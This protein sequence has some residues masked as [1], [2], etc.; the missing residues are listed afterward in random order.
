MKKS[1]PTHVISYFNSFP[2]LT[3]ALLLILWFSSSMLLITAQSVVEQNGRLTVTG[4]KVTNQSGSPISLAGNSIFWSNYSEGAQFYTAQ[5]VSKIAGPEWNSSII[6]AA[7]GVEDYNGYISNP[8]QEKAKV[9]AIVDAAIAEGIYVI[10]DWHSHNAEDYQN[11]AVQFFTE[12]SQLYGSYPNVIYE[13]YNEPIGQPWSEIKAYA[14]AVTQAIRSNDPDNLIVVGTSFY[15]QKVTQASLNPLNDQNTAYT[16]HFYAGT[17]GESLR[18]DARTAM[19]NGIA[20]FVTEWGAVNANGDGGAAIEET[21][22]WMEFL[23]ENHISHAN[24]SISD[25][26]E[27]ASV[28]ASGTGINGLIANNLTTIGFFVQ[29]IIKNWTTSITP[30][31]T[32][33]T[34]YAIHNI[35]GTIEAED[36]DN[37]GN[38]VAYFDSTSGNYGNSLRSDD[39]DKE[40]TTDTGGGHNVG[41]TTDG[42]WLEYT[43]S[44][45]TAGTYDI[46]FRV[47]STRSSNKSISLSLE[48]TSLGTIAV[49]NTSGWQQWETVTLRDIFIAGGKDQVMRF[50]FNDGA[51]NLN[52]TTFISRPSNS[53]TQYTI[54]AKGVTGEEKIELV[55]D[56]TTLGTFNLSKN[57]KEFTVATTVTGTPR[58]TY[59]NDSYTRDAEIDWLRIDGST[60][61][62]E[63]Q[64]TN[65]SV[66]QDNSC[67]GSYSQIMNCPGFIEFDNS[68]STTGALEIS[69]ENVTLFPNPMADEVRIVSTNSN[70][71]FG[72]LLIT[73]VTGATV[74][75]GNL[76]SSNAVQIQHLPPGIYFATIQVNGNLIKKTMVKK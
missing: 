43:I 1:T 4:N 63:A 23:K 50:S 35:P 62:A 46:E 67:G 37:G 17:H 61:Q 13:V 19:N 30:S 66:Y 33:Q 29:D 8:A 31:P 7:M 34:A 52:K 64:P 41:F 73:N 24:W 16:L 70:D 48:G 55:I 68:P 26:N 58:I 56:Q 12:M 3:L 9:I 51:F 42:E 2:K 38:S 72:D 45:I 65:T 47:A 32:N 10:I 44:N 71:T 69:N 27:G 28:V 11:Q 54:R 60:L 57:F 14:E 39:V 75:E 5:T 22:K 76:K 36:Y 6:R 40:P 59:I 20:L 74:L 21:N 18:N 53:D 25:K 15:S 49:P